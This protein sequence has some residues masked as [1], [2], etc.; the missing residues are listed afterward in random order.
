MGLGESRSLSTLFSRVR[1]MRETKTTLRKFSFQN[2][3]VLNK[4]VMRTYNIISK[5]EIIRGSDKPPTNRMVMEYAS[6][7]KE[8]THFCERIR[9]L[10]QM[11]TRGIILLHNQINHYTWKLQKFKDTS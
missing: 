8:F 5:G 11:N 9:R 7:G 2:Q 6:N 3:T 10:C 1:C 4:H